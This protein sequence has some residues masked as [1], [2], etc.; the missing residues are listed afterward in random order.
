MKVLISAYACAPGEG[1]EPGVGWNWALQAARVADVWVLTRSNNRP[2]IEE[3][4]ARHPVPNLHFVYHD[5]PRWARS[6][7]RGSKGVRLYYILWQLTAVPKVFTF[8]RRIRFDIVH[9]LTFNAIDNA[10]FLWLLNCR[11][12]WGPVGGAQ[13]PPAAL[14]EYFGQAWRREQ[15]R[16]LRK[17]LLR[18]NPFVRLAIFR[19][20][21]ILASNADTEQA[22]RRLGA[23]RLV[24]LLEAGVNSPSP[25]KGERS[26]GHDSKPLT[27]IWAGG[28]VLR[29]APKLAIDVVE[30]LVSRHSPIHLLMIGDGP[31]RSSVEREIHARELHEFVTLVGA[32]PHPEMPRWYAQGDVFL[33]TSLQDTSGNVVL[34]AMA[35]G[36]PVIA[37]DHQGAAEMVSPETGYKIPILNAK[38]VIADLADAIETLASSPDLRLRMGE[39]ARR[40]AEQTFGWSR[41]ALILRDVYASKTA[42]TLHSERDASQAN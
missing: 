22:L 14:K 41:K 27:V 21:C 17:R 37:L 3:E 26:I 40:R 9:H 25:A 35:Q 32:V 5:L 8:H 11:F 7:K 28:F 13:V 23:K 42:W 1:S 30:E 38:Q 4:L 6:W 20:D 36:L 29:K 18:L 34:E 12:V 31:L 16:A 39:A 33:F 2:A 10:G 19:A 24:R 15:I